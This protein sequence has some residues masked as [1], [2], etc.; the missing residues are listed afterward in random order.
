M[1][2]KQ[3]GYNSYCSMFGEHKGNPCSCGW[4]SKNDFEEFG[5]DMVYYIRMMKKETGTTDDP[6]LGELLAWVMIK[7][8]D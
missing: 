7:A 4:S 1:T 5:Q 8:W 6:S 3:Y 2:V